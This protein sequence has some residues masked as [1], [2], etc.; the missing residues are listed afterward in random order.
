MFCYTTSATL[1]CF[2][3]GSRTYWLLIIGAAACA[4]AL[5][6]GFF[7]LAFPFRAWRRRP[8]ARPSRVRHR[9]SYEWDDC[10][11]D[12]IQS[13][14]DN[15]HVTV[16]YQTTSTT[17][18]RIKVRGDRIRAFQRGVGLDDLSNSREETLLRGACVMMEQRFTLR[19]DSTIVLQPNDVATKRFGDM[20]SGR[21]SIE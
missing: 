15:G 13:H 14:I 20:R 11:I 3:Y 16:R 5:C 9:D 6:A 4:I 8:H 21:A 7:A 12:H 17:R 10:R 2:E 19:D 18:G 1:N